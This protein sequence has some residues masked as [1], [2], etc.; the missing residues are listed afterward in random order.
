MNVHTFSL[1]APT[2]CSK[3]FVATFE[4]KYLTRGNALRLFFLFLEELGAPLLKRCRHSSCSE[5]C[6]GGTS[7]T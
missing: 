2:E 6:N 1:K 4:G 7:I 5:C 3:K